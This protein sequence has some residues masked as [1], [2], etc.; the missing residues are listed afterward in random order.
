[1]FAK[2]IRGGMPVYDAN[3]AGRHRTVLQCI[4]SHDNNYTLIRI[5]L[6]A[7]VI[8]FH[9]FAVVKTDLR[10]RISDFILPITSV[11]GLAVEAFFFLSGLFVAQSIFKDRNIASFV[12]K[13]FFRIWPGL[14][15]CL[16][17]TAAIFVTST[18]SHSVTKTLTFDGFYSYVV[19]NAL[20]SIE[21][22]IP[23]TLTT[24]PSSALNGSIHTLPLEAKMYVALA[25][26]ALLGG[27]SRVISIMI[28]AV[29]V[30]AI[31]VTPVRELPGFSWIFPSTYSHVAYTMFFAGVFVFGASNWLVPRLW[32][33]LFL[34]VFTYLSTGT[35]HIIC[36]YLFV[37]WAILFLGEWSKLGAIFRPSQDISY[38]I[39]IYGWPSAQMVLLLTRPTLNPYVLTVGSIA[40]AS[41]FAIFSWNVIEKPT[42]AFGRR[43][44]STG[45][46]F[47]SRT[48]FSQL[49][50]SAKSYP[51]RC[52]V[53][54]CVAFVF[55]ASMKYL[56]YR[57]P[58]APIVPMPLKIVT[59]GPQEGKAGMPVNAQPDGSS[60]IWILLDSMPKDGATVVFSGQRLSTA[61]GKNAVTATLSKNLIATSGDKT[62]YIERRLVDRIERSKSVTMHITP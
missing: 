9:A 40:L 28:A 18:S 34:A 37:I 3:A 8:Y 32:Q 7:S 26:I 21:Y 45:L 49:F 6:A 54:L 42:I 33:G 25:I 19:N 55:C 27:T 16:L 46:R 58:F 47:W 52:F 17:I 10:D 38:G 5:F 56:T 13:R 24:L 62:I 61:M 53:V 11:G 29:V 59:F 4:S 51:G 1:M 43:L 30:M 39:Y 22:F 12:S 36:F 48:H 50:G 35:P 2:K 23:Q 15:F 41:I 14:F 31:T 60:A 44:G 57:Y 20:F